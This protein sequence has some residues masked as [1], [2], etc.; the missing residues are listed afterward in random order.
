MGSVEFA[1]EILGAAVEALA[2]VE[3]Y[4]YVTGSDSP[5]CCTNAFSVFDVSN[6]AAP[7]RVGQQRPF[8]TT[9]FQIREVG[10]CACIAGV[11]SEENLMLIDVSNRSQPVRKPGFLLGG[12]T[13]I[14]VAGQYLYVAS[15]NYHL[16]KYGEER[17]FIVDVSSPGNPVLAARALTQG[18]GGGVDV[19][20]HYA[21]VAVNKGNLDTLNGLEVF[22]ISNPA[23]PVSVGT[24][25][26]G[27]WTRHIQVQDHYAYLSGELRA[28]LDQTWLE[29][30]NL[31]DPTQP[32]LVGRSKLWDGDPRGY[33][34]DSFQVVG[35]LI[36]VADGAWGLTIMEIELPGTLK[37][38]PPV[39]SGNTITLTWNGGPSI[40]LQ[41]TTSLSALNWQDVS[42]SEGLSQ[43]ELPCAEAAAFFRLMKP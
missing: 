10:D 27:L 2:V 20:G 43:I 33:G 36:Y 41:K 30:I 7:A 32:R 37:L 17:F 24:C 14:S 19:A 15:A 11:G 5:I 9:A 3:P 12:H 4:V 18:E 16:T 21:Y 26:G 34:S 42:G 29:V 13:S 6:P 8:D 31:K 25:E 39:L 22:D 28:A 23:M 38:K 1:A 40:K 35:N